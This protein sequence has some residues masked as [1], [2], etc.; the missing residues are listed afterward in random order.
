MEITCP[1]C[2]HKWNASK[3]AEI[4]I[5]SGWKGKGSIEIY[6]GVDEDFIII[7]YVKDKNTREIEKRKHTVKKEDFNRMARIIKKLQIGEV[8]KCYWFPKQFG[9]I[10][11]QEFWKVRKVYLRIYYYPLKVLE[12]LSMI[13]YGS[14]TT[15]RLR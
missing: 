11:W 4:E 15:Q 3:K 9:Y 5:L 8:V 12:S 10:N 6:K 13:K 7:E 1:Q 14:R 2:K